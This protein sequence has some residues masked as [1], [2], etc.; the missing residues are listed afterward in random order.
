MLILCFFHQ[1]QQKKKHTH[2]QMGYY[3][4]NPN[5]WIFHQIVLDIGRSLPF[6]EIQ[7][8][9]K[10]PLEIPHYF[11][12]AITLSYPPTVIDDSS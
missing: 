3:R 1:Q 6:L 9:T 4:K 12:G 7:P 2:T 8:K 11:F 5:P 10:T